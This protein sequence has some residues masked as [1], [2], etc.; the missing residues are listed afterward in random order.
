MSRM[1]RYAVAIS[2]VSLLSLGTAL[3]A[4]SAA[5]AGGVK[6]DPQPE[7]V[8]FKIGAASSPGSV[9]IE[10]NGSIVTAYD[11]SSNKLVVCVLARGG[12]KCS[13]KTTITTHGD[14]NILFGTPQVFAPSANQVV[15]LQNTTEFDYLYTS[16]DGGASFGA[17]VQVGTPSALGVTAAALIDGHIV[18]GAGDDSSGA[19]VESVS[20]GASGPPAG[21][22]TATKQA[23]TDF[24]V[25][26][27]KGGALVASDF[28]GTHYTTYVAFAPP[29]SNF[30]ASSSYH[31]VGKFSREQLIGI[32]GG[33]LL[34]MSATGKQSLELRLFNGTS[35]GPPHA[36]PGL[37]G[38]GPEWF[39][40]DQEPSGRVHVFS[41]STHSSKI[42]ELIERSTS[43]GSNWSRAVD[44]GNAT[45]NNTF[46]VALDSRGTGLVLGTDPAWGYP[47]LGTQS[48]S[49]SLKA[50]TIKKGHSTTGSGV[51]SPAGKGR[52][53][54]LQVERSGRWYDVATAHESSSGSFSFT[55]KGT[56]AGHFDY[57]AVV[58]DLA[59]YLQ[60]GYSAARSL[61]V[62]G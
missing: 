60:Y 45:R 54:E 28:D 50:S 19:Q 62:T 9:A 14:A 2:T 31:N 59:G 15:V 27:Y 25:G 23:A 38:G 7:L 52:T 17:P 58:S 53:V 44:L 43:N 11:I 48:V 33:A 34:T 51:G 55:I 46:A 49:F 61:H 42:Y 37:N 16:T 5:P 8:P 56:A 39:T 18:F 36:V 57:R 35:F 4:A 29:F 10:S 21:F 30:N 1:R 40:I 32:S 12:H 22:A 20:V 13:R 24:G 47:V 26:S 3:T 41:S 6:G